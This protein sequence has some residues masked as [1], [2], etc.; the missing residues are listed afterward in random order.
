MTDRLSHSNWNTVVMRTS[1]GD[2]VHTHFTNTNIILIRFLFSLFRL[3]L[4]TGD[5]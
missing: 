1:A 4:I 5:I 3:S 2:S